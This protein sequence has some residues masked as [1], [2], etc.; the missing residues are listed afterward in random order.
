METCAKS[1][2]KLGE[3]LKTMDSMSDRP[4]RSLEVLQRDVDKI[5]DQ[6]RKLHGRADWKDLVVNMRCAGVG[7]LHFSQAL[8]EIMVLFGAD[9]LQSAKSINASQP[10]PDLPAA[11]SKS[12]SSKSCRSRLLRWVA[13]ALSDKNKEF[14]GRT[15]ESGGTMN[16]DSLAIESDDENV[17][18]SSLCSPPVSAKRQ[19]APKRRVAPAPPA[20]G[21]LT[22]RSAPDKPATQQPQPKALHRKG[23]NSRH[24]HHP[25]LLDQKYNMYL[26][27]VRSDTR[28]CVHCFV[29]G[30]VLQIV[31]HVFRCH[32]KV[33]ELLQ[34]MV[35]DSAAMMSLLAK[36]EQQSA[37]QV[38]KEEL[39]ATPPAPQEAVEISGDEEPAPPV[40]NKE[41]QTPRRRRR[42]GCYSSCS[43][44]ARLCF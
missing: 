8:Q 11:A 27:S 44:Q 2:S 5:A 37:K 3:P 21:S 38:V 14:T 10:C 28:I 6:M 18:A 34:R 32:K 20:A 1:L 36:M 25:P 26:S 15:A 17:D 42:C 24:P 41:D 13:H 29:H 4:G 23:D 30:F 19:G 40:K 12:S 22:P 9:F 16:F 43:Q 33:A 31:F 39:Q 7:L 35:A